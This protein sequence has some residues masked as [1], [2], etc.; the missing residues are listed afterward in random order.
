L[1]TTNPQQLL[2]IEQ[3]QKKFAVEVSTN[4]PPEKETSPLEEPLG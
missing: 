3:A 4:Q 2:E 1:I